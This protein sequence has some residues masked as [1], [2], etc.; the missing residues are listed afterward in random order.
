MVKRGELKSKDVKNDTVIYYASDG[1]PYEK[2]ADGKGEARCIAEEVPFELPEGGA[3]A[4]LSCV[5]GLINYGVSNSA[6]DEGSH[7]LLRITDIH[8]Q[9]VEWESVP[10][11]TVDVKTAE[12]CGVEDGDI[13][14]ARIGATVGK[15]YLASG[16]PN[17]AVYASYL[18]R[19]QPL[20]GLSHYLIQFCDSPYYWQQISANAVGSGRPNVNGSVL[21]KLFIPV[22]PLPEQ[23]RIVAALDRRL[24][25]VD[26]VER[27]GEELGS[28]F[29]RLRS[30]VLDLAIRGELTERDPSDE[31]AGELL[32]RI[33]AEKLA[34]VGRGE[35]KRKDVSGDTVIFTGSDGLRYEKPADG[36]GEPV[37]IEDEI[38]FEIPET[39]AWARL[40][41]PVA[42]DPKNNVDDETE[43]SFLPMAAI[44]D[45]FKG[46]YHP[47]I[48]LWKDI[49][50]GF[51]QFA[52]G[53]VVFAKISPCFENGKYFVAHDL[54][55]GVGAGNTEL[56][57]LRSPRVGLNHMYLFYFLAS[58]YFTGDATKTFMGTVGQQRIKKDYLKKMLLPVPPLAEQQR[59]VEKMET[60]LYQFR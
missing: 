14:F 19:I 16:T 8:R 35:L 39:W 25:L 31:P 12:K 11:T 54:R 42:L 1:L 52:D 17:N 2:P 27:D 22:P 36:R 18:I 13:L 47:E 49:K 15:T 24:S 53:D 30:K 9:H 23:R 5:C 34:M 50:K 38:P 60:I 44:D 6:E 7:K 41:T 3:W 26:T 43:A 46:T 40:L 57:V 4:R 48:R 28:L 29:G 37:C 20:F 59:I 21:S 56:F 32:A 51:T 55:N 33:H 58:D 45:D 10:F